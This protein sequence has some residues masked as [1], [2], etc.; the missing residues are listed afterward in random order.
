MAADDTS[1]TFADSAHAHIGRK[2]RRTRAALMAGTTLVFTALLPAWAFAQR[3]SFD[4]P[5]VPPETLDSARAAFDESALRMQLPA[6][7]FVAVIGSLTSD[8]AVLGQSFMRGVWLAFD[9]AI[10]NLRDTDA[11]WTPVDKRAG[12][13]L[14]TSPLEH[15]FQVVMLDDH[16]SPEIA[17][18]YAKV[19]VALPN[20]LAIVGS[21]NSDCTRAVEEVV[22]SAASRPLPLLS[23][24]STHSSLGKDTVPDARAL[25]RA[26][27]ADLRERPAGG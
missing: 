24:I 13:K 3:V 18:R 7:P 26:A 16:S 23:P 27:R 22:N 4:G 6:T 11:A 5:F 10:D 21:V 12:Y 17:A 15:P 19:I 9:E 20:A 1:N 25:H 2:R 14:T 8:T